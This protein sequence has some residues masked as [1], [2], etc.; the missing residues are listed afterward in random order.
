MIG[1]SRDQS[2]I[3]LLSLAGPNDKSAAKRMNI[4][5]GPPGA[6]YRDEILGTK[7]FGGRAAGYDQ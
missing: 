6:R 5:I 4:N 7:S 1:N 3:R 2:G